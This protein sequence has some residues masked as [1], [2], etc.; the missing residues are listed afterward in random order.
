[1]PLSIPLATVD[2]L[3]VTTL[4]DNVFDV[5]MPDQGPAQRL[6]PASDPRTRPVATMVGGLVPDQLI[7]EHGLSL[8]L[9]ITRD[10]QSHQLLFDT[11]VVRMA[12]SPTWTVCR[13]IRRT[14]KPSCAVTATTTTPRTRRIDSPHGRH[15]L[16]SFA[17][18]G[19]LKR[20]RVRI[21]GREPREIPTTS[22]SALQ[23]AG[24]KLSR[25]ASRAS[26]STTACW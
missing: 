1:M 8:L 26:C 4:V 19:L 21:S 5:F 24:S 14:S 17:A 16:A 7:A 20:R 10:G 6:S 9:T 12:W 18:S 13:S 11:G 25:S 2:S 15:Q 3:T 22:R 23:G